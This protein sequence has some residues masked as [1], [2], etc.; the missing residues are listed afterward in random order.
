M[1]DFD[2]LP[3]I[4]TQGE[5]DKARR[6]NRWLGR[7]EGVAGIVAFGAVMNLLGWVP[8]LLVLAIVGYVV[9]KLLSKKGSGD[10]G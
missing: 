7:V 1:K 8:S 4:F 10:E 2:N 3:E 6:R 9:W 5:I